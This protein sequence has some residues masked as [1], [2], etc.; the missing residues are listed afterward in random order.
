MAETTAAS[1]ATPIPKERVGVVGLGRMGRAIA[2]ALVRA[3]C[4][5]SGWTRSGITPEGAATLGIAA[6]ADL[7][8]L[9]A[10]SDIIVVSLI[11]DTA[12]GTMLGALAA[13]DLTGKL[14][15]ETST[16]SPTVLRGHESAIRAARGRAIDAPIAGGPD[17]LRAGTAG[18]YMGGDADDVA[19]FQPFAALLSNRILHVGPLGHGAAAKIVNNMM[20]VGFWQ[21]LKEALSVGK[22][23][24]LSLET[25]FEILSKSPAA[26][27]AMLQRAPVILGTSDAVGFTVAGATKDNALC[28]RLARE[29]ELEVPAMTAALASFTAHRDSGNA[30]R[31]LATMV[32][33]G[34]QSA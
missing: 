22:R 2:G 17:T 11:D 16:V 15:V 34:Y 31:D 30:E 27:P 13:T 18:F 32:F 5:V 8:A 1:T 23:S 25:M 4:S 19:R 14:I 24:G 7:T 29:L 10:T 33:A 21:T 9:V 26:N 3:G 12:V 20:L 28:V 6:H